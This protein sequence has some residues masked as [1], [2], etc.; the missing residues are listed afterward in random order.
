M[1]NTIL[2]LTTDNFWKPFQAISK[3]TVHFG[4]SYPEY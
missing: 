3:L 2:I 4:F 1:E